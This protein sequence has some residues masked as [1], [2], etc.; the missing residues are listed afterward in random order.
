[1]NL[2]AIGLRLIGLVLLITQTI[3]ILW[4]MTPNFPSADLL[5]IVLTSFGL[6]NVAEEIH[7]NKS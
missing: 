6:A 1:M 3:Q 7:N 4:S 2:V 5:I